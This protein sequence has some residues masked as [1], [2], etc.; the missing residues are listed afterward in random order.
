M[1]AI[2]NRDHQLVVRLLRDLA[3]RPC[4][5]IKE[6]NASRQAG[7]LAHKLTRK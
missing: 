6:A 5:S 1:K 4:A 7:C 3:K 2:S